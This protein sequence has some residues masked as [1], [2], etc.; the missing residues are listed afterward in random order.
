MKIY[1]DLH[2][3]TNFFNIPK[4]GREEIESFGAELI[5]DYDESVTIYFGD[6]LEKKDV[7]SL[8]NLKWIHFPS[9][10]VNRALI[11]EVIN[12]DII[13]TN[14]KGLFNKSVTSMVISYIT[15]FSKGFHYI[16]KLRN[17]NNLN[18]KSFD[19]FL[20]F[21]K[22]PFFSG[23]K[24]LIVGHGSIGNELSDICSYLGIKVDSVRSKDNIKECIKES[25]ADFVVNLL[26]LTP[27]TDSVF[28]YET[29][30]Y[31]KSDS[32]FLNLG[33]GQSVIEE[34]LIDALKH[35]VIAGAGLDV[36]RIEPLPLDSE[37]W[38]LDNVLITPHIANLDKNY[39]KNEIPLFI[40][41]LKSFKNNSKLKNIINL[42]RGY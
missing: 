6:L 14:S 30:E 12:S 11:P 1:T 25:K 37:L 32:Y 22:E 36:F 23:L 29:F 5:H 42:E 13:V 41:N 21:V 24:C 20:P 31:M 19:E 17:E 18:R 16:E 40:D 38:E 9:V 4:W 39:W 10:G 15:Y 2:S 33:R 35:K 28:D 7:M 3:R 27:K 26:P 8:P 34:D